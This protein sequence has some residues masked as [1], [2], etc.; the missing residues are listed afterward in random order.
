MRVSAQELEPR[1]Y[2][3]APVGTNF[4]GLTYTRLSGQVLVDPSIPITDVQAQINSAS[5]GYVH[6]FNLAGHGASFGL[7]APF[8]SGDISGKVFDAPN[9]VHRAG[10]GDARFRLSVNLLGGPALTPEEFAHR[11]PGTIVGMSLT[12]VAPTGQYEPAHLVNIGTHR[13]AFK[14]EFGISQP[15]GNWFAEVMTGVWLFTDNTSFLGNRRR[16][17][18]PLAELQLHGGY[19]FRPGL[20]LAADVGF[21]SG[22]ATSVNGV[23]GDD[24]QNNAR[25][26]LTLSVPITRD[27][28]A[29]LAVS[30]GFVV[31]A[32]GNYKAI[33]LT[34]QY[35]WFNR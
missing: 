5:I 8:V 14:P 29:K 17:Q 34:L 4:I 18:A 22:G 6:V 12:V 23:T 13:W 21:S 1:A 31:R 25:Y 3:P 24:R 16:A 19:T 20:W 33:S 26:G 32:G 10:I 28:S 7:L 2:S 27:W 9:Q 35:R 30:N 11:T 15:F